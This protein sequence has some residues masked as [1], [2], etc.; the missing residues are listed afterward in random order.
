VPWCVRTDGNDGNSGDINNAGGAFKTITGA[1]IAIA[2]HIDA[3]GYAVT[4]QIADGIYNDAIY[5][6]LAIPNTSQVN[7]RGNVATPANVTIS[8]S[9]HGGFSVSGVT[10]EISGMTLSNARAIGQAVLV[11]NR[12]SLSIGQGVVF[13]PCPNRC[14]LEI[15]GGSMISAAQNYTISGSAPSHVSLSNQSIFVASSRTVTLTGTPA[16]AKGFIQ[17]AQGATAILYANIW[18]GASTGLRYRVTGNSAIDSFAAGAKFAGG[19]G[20]HSGHGRGL[21]VMPLV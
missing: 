12:G 9:G 8:P 16:F 11:S 13:G 5:V 21:C 15:T 1:Y 3:A 10:I 19:F 14:H 20:R 4:L 17:A 6:A 18:F 7:L 2:R